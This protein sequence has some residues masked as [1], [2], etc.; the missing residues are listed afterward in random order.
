MS[1]LEEAV[2]WSD[3]ELFHQQQTHEYALLPEVPLGNPYALLIVL[4]AARRILEDAHSV[5]LLSRTHPGQLGHFLRNT[6][7]WKLDK[8][9]QH[10]AYET[11]DPRCS[12][13]VDESWACL[14]DFGFDTLKREEWFA[15]LTRTPLLLRR[16][17]GT[18]ASSGTF[19]AGTASAGHSIP[20]NSDRP[21]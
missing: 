20:C 7:A 10:H 13:A 5:D 3:D 21:S 6:S 4:N 11:M 9:D 12:D 14:L 15:F 1:D 19:E 2:W 18:S 17:T 8:A 16:F